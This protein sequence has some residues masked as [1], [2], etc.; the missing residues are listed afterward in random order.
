[1]KLGAALS[2]SPLGYSTQKGYGDVEVVPVM[3]KVVLGSQPSQ[4]WQLQYI[5]FSGMSSLFYIYVSVAFQVRKH[6]TSGC[7]GVAARTKGVRESHRMESELRGAGKANRK[8]KSLA[9]G[10]HFLRKYSGSENMWHD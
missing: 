2:L 6:C 5:L 9:S 1:M 10:T 7:P 8:E 4:P 3:G